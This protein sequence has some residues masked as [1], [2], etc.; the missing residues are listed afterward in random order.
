MPRLHL[1]LLLV[2][3]AC[4]GGVSDALTAP[5]ASPDR[6]SECSEPKQGRIWCD[7]FE[8]DRTS[9]YFEYDTAGGS[10]VRVAG[11]G[12]SGSA[13]MRVRWK[14]G[15]VGAGSLHL[16]F[17]KTPSSY[18]KPVDA[19]TANY[20]ELYWRMYVRFQDGWTGGG[21]DKLSRAI[22]FASSDWAEA[23]I[24]HV[25]SMKTNFV[26]L[27]PASGTD[28]FGTLKTT[29]YNDNP[30][31]RWLGAQSSATPIFDAEH[32]G[33]WYC[34][35]AHMKL[36]DVGESNGVNELW[37]NDALEAQATTLNWLGI[38]ND[39]GINAVFFENYWNDGSPATQERYFD[40]IVVST[41]RIGCG[42]TP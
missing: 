31:L 16:A 39:Y 32:V 3:F 4:K 33:K 25:W 14:P 20:R 24:S 41:Q 42:A 13:G 5:P 22:V 35:E 37:V 6:A 8:S 11:V 26:G 9:S 40:N 23:A 34:V 15:Q 27:D 28:T 38:F 36:N 21:G 12:I 7:D 2:V 17:G 1:I 18:I 30:N 10:F 29:V 19:G